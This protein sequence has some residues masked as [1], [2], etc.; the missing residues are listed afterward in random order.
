MGE[1]ICYA[2][3]GDVRYGGLIVQIYNINCLIDWVMQLCIIIIIKLKLINYIYT[4]M[5]QQ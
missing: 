3:F 5:D 1:Y 2:Y 4:T